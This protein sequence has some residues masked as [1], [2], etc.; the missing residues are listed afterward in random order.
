MLDINAYNNLMGRMTAMQKRIEAI[1]ESMQLPPASLTPIPLWNRTE[2]VRKIKEAIAERFPR[3]D[4]FGQRH[5]ADDVFPRHLAMYLLRTLAKLSLPEVGRS[6]GG[7]HHTTVFYAVNK[8]AHE[9]T[10]DPFTDKIL[11]EIE[12]LIEGDFME[13]KNA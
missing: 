6:M 11:K 9:R 2:T 7:K 4:V 3:C 10:V 1:E 12:A 8:I 13:K 5:T